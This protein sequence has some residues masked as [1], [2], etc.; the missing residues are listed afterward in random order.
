M[1]STS[2]PEPKTAAQRQADYR[3]RRAYA[4]PSG[5][6]EKRLGVWVSMAASQALTRLA[7][8][9]GL[10]QRQ[11]LEN[12]IVAAD[13]QVTAGMSDSEFETYLASVTL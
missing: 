1:Q 11:W 13:K 6:G 2:K 8:R 10:T 4:G 7:K 12:A 9:D 5:D 3:K